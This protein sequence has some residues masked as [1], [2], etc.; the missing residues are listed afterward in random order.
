MATFA[1]ACAAFFQGVA[2]GGELEL[3]RFHGEA[4]FLTDLLLDRFD[5]FA[6]ELHDLFAVLANE[7]VM[8]GVVGI[9]GIIKLVRLPKVHLMQKVALSE[10]K[11]RAVNR[12]AGNGAILF[13]RPIEQL[14]GG[15]MLISIEH[16]VDDDSPLVGVAKFLFLKK[17]DEF[18][19]RRLSR[20]RPHG[21]DCRPIA[22][23]SQ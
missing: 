8:V 22:P 21:R 6:V 16:R 5:L 11:Q 15:E 23:P 19:L 13:A 9:V 7:V 4:Q 17:I 12:G 2:G 14:L 10:Q 3:L 1:I 18:P 20:F